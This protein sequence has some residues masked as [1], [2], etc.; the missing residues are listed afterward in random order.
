MQKNLP[1]TGVT[2]EGACKG[3]QPD[4]PET[5]ALYARSLQTCLVDS[6]HPSLCTPCKKHMTITH[7]KLSERKSTC[8]VHGH[9]GSELRSTTPLCATDHGMWSASFTL[10]VHCI[11]V[12][13]PMWHPPC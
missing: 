11:L 8:S 2:H 7:K 4:R 1:T 13:F 9:S 3:Q 6:M 5:S 10:P 12:P